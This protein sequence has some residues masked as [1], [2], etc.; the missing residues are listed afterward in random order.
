MDLPVVFIP[1]LLSDA[2]LFDAQNAALAAAGVPTMAFAATGADNIVAIAAGIL[3]HAP[4]KFIL[5]GL[6]MGGYV[7]MEIMRQAPA[8]VSKLILMN[9][10]ARADSPEQLEKR[11]ALIQLAQ[12]GRFKGVTPRLL[13]LLIN[14][15]HLQN[16][17]MT[18]IIF[19]MAERMGRDNFVQ[20]QTAIMGR[21]DSRPSL[22]AI[23][24]PT[25]IIGGVDDKIAPP[26]LSRE[27]AALIPGA[28]L[29]VL[30]DCG[31]LSAL[32]QPEQVNALIKKFIGVV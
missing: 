4:E 15:K 31:H 10:S 17:V 11:A 2:T 8:R 19:D 28:A 24:V 21:A 1:G 23:K 25:L 12:I 13:P 26:D 20:Q 32:E 27:M 14:E 3:A 6:S 16:T 18:K 7:C 30:D 22:S 9:T 29:H 5:A